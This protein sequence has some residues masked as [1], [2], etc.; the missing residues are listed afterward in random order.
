MKAVSIRELIKKVLA[1]GTISTAVP[2]KTNSNVWKSGTITL[3]RRSGL[4][5]V[6]FNAVVLGTVSARTDFAIIPEG[7]RPIVETGGILDSS[8]LWFFCRPNGTLAINPVTASTTV[9]GAVTYMIPGGGT[10]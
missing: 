3:Y 2:T 5:T 6:K 10:A 4:V 7:Y 1:F 8:N 9:W